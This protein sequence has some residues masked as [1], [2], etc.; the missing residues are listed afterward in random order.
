MLQ[1]KKLGPKMSAVGE[2]MR[3]QIQPKSSTLYKSDNND[4]GV[5]TKD[6]LTHTHWQSY[7][8]C[9]EIIQQ[10]TEYMAN[11]KTNFILWEN[12]DQWETLRTNLKPKYERAQLNLIA[13][14][15]SEISYKEGKK[16][17]KHC[18]LNRN[19]FVEQKK[20]IFLFIF[21]LKLAEMKKNDNKKPK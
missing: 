15:I 5:A 10:H 4:E 3:Q 17:P 12:G 7:R 20:R 19:S 6:T 1:E 9:I 2:K 13:V 21:F 16:S 11:I 18:L 8:I 14:E